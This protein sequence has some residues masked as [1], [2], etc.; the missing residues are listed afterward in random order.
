MNHFLK[1][2]LLALAL[3]IG[4]TKTVS[5]LP[6]IQGAVNFG[7][8]VANIQ[9]PTMNSATFI[10][11]PAFTV[12][13]PAT[14][15]FNSSLGSGGTATNITNNLPMSGLL[16]FNGFTVDVSSYLG[17]NA[18]VI[19]SLLGG[20]DFVSLAFD[21]VVKKAGFE[22]TAVKGALSA[23]YSSGYNA[24]TTIAWSGNLTSQVPEP[25]TFGLIGAGL[26]GIAALRRRQSS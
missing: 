21:G 11:T 9:I 12:I 3:M 16:S 26:I 7:S 17:P 23:Q 4:L 25:M 14:G 22:D 2:G 18:W 24:N 1:T 15:D 20:I 19:T 10:G 13:T 5:A 8:P 6:Y